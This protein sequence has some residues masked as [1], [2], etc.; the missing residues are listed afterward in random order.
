VPAFHRDLEADRSERSHR[1]SPSVGASTDSTPQEMLLQV[2]AIGQPAF[3]Y[4]GVGLVIP[5]SAASR[6]SRLVQEPAAWLETGSLA[7]VCTMGRPNGASYTG[8]GSLEVS[9]FIWRSLQVFRLR[10]GNRSFWW[11]SACRC[12]PPVALW[13]QLSV[14]GP[15]ERTGSFKGRWT[16]DTFRPSF[17][18]AIRPPEYLQ[19]TGLGAANASRARRSRLTH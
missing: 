8:I 18:E 16:F 1:A 19:A 14:D 6:F 11:P 4:A 5:C 2:R 3:S 7:A 13:I 17:S 12:S 15:G 10:W 9:L